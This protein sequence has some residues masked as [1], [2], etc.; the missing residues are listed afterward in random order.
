MYNIDRE[1]ELITNLDDFFA[2]HESKGHCLTAHVVPEKK[3]LIYKLN[4]MPRAK[5]TGDIVMS[6]RFFSIAQALKAIQEALECFKEDIVA[7]RKHLDNPYFEIQYT[8]DTFTGEGICKGACYNDLISVHG[9][10]VV[11][12]K[13]DSLG[14]TFYIKT[15][16]PNCAF[17]DVDYVYEAMDKWQNNRIT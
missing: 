7:W 4:K 1:I 14:R 6:T 16:Y 2:V 13:G 11:L 10:R 17:E 8:S 5:D 12:I 9:L 3:E 15:A